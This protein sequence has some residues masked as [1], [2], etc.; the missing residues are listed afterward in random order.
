MLKI[1]TVE[2]LQPE[3][4]AGCTMFGV[5]FFSTL[6]LRPKMPA[7]TVTIPLSVALKAKKHI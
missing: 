7:K 1:K 5:F 3:P 2:K 4:Q 6:T